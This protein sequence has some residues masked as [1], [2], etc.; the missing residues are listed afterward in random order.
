MDTSTL[1][2]IAEDYV[3]FELQRGGL[4]VAKPK[5]DRSGTDLLV[6]EQIGDGVKFCRLQV[7]GRSLISSKT[8]NI[9][10]KKEYVTNAFVVFLYLE[11][12]DSENQPKLF[13]FFRSDVEKWNS[14]PKDEFQLNVNVSTYEKNLAG[15][16]YNNIEL[17]KIKYII[18]AAEIAGEF[19][20]ITFL[21]AQ[22]KKKT[23]KTT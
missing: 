17:G 1:E 23:N 5:N 6:F 18:S 4:L 16:S 11:V 14:T 9:T 19:R 3:S 12:P 13:V 15:F 22:L 7:K 2:N 8:T 20:R 21:S 10:I